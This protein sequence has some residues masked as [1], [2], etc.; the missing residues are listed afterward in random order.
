MARKRTLYV[1]SLWVFGGVVLAVPVLAGQDE[2]AEPVKK[3]GPVTAET[4]TAEDGMVAQDAAV[5]PLEPL[6][7]VVDLGS[8]GGG[9]HKD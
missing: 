5:N 2:S 8:V 1:A 6:G 7:P 4:E 3:N 9:C